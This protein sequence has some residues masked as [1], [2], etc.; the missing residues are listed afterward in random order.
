MQI[1]INYTI[2]K[3]IQEITMLLFYK[4]NIHLSE[5]QYQD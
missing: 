5:K 3:I 4:L 1:R 2:E